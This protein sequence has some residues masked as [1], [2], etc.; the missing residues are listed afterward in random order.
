MIAAAHGGADDAGHLGRVCRRGHAEQREAALHQAAAVSAVG[1]D[2]ALRKPRR[3]TRVEHVDVV[4]VARDAWHRL[5]TGDHRFVGDG[6]GHVAGAAVV[7]LDEELH[8]RKAGQH[9][10][11]PLAERRMED[12]GF[13]VAVVEQVPQLLVEVAVVHIDRHAAH[14]EARELGLQVLVG[15]VQVETDLAVG[16]ETGGDE[17]IREP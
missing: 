6:P 5:V 4:L 9:P 13:G 11:H 17:R 14:L 7:H 2:D 12:D 10:G 1:V 8:L 16:P 3:A 15:V